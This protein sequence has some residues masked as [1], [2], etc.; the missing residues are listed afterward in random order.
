MLLYKTIRPFPFVD[1]LLDLLCIF[2]CLHCGA[3]I[4]H[5]L[6]IKQIKMGRAAVGPWSRGARAAVAGLGANSDQFNIKIDQVDELPD[7]RID[8]G[9][10]DLLQSGRAELSP[11]RT[12]PWPSRR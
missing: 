5:E 4:D 12:K 10:G 9:A 8:I 3:N 1:A 11:R 6:L 2:H 7:P